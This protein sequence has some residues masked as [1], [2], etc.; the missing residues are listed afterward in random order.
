MSG[1]L[2]LL[3]DIVTNRR[4]MGNGVMDLVAMRT[5]FLL[6]SRMV[7]D[8]RWNPRWTAGNIA[9]QSVRS[10]TESSSHFPHYSIA[11]RR[12]DAMPCATYHHCTSMHASRTLNLMGGCVVEQS[13]MDGG[14]D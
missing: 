2:L 3:A 7:D 11:V 9:G 10:N 4:E 13:R 6:S 1:E 14:D 5:I 8:E 12:C